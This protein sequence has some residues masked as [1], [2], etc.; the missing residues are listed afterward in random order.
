MELQI[1]D[2][3]YILFFMVG[4]PFVVGKIVNRVFKVKDNDESFN[5]WY[6]GIMSSSIFGI[7][8]FLIYQIFKMIIELI[9]K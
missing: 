1:L 8:L 5:V 2:F 6:T 3:V 4:L 9:N 7:I